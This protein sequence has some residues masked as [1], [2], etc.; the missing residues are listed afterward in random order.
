MRKIDIETKVIQG[1]YQPSRDNKPV[2]MDRLERTPKPPP[3]YPPHLQKLWQD[4]C[5]DLK[6]HGYLSKAFMQNLKLMFDW[7]MVYEEARNALLLEGLTI[8]KEGSKKQMRLI[9]NPNLDT[10][11]L[12]MTWITKI[13]EKFGFTPVDFLKLPPVNIEKQNTKS[14]LK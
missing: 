9:R 6:N 7:V 4:R 1:T 3:G 2:S 13:S 12:A 14:L 11:N 5:Q 10:M 8:E